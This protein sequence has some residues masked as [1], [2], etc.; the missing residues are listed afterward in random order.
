MS[1][2]R[3]LR[4]ELIIVEDIRRFFYVVCKTILFKEYSWKFQ[5]RWLQLIQVQC[6]LHSSEE[7]SPLDLLEVSFMHRQ[8]LVETSPDYLEWD[9]AWHKWNLYWMRDDCQFIWKTIT[10]LVYFTKALSVKKLSVVL[11]NFLQLCLNFGSQ[12]TVSHKQS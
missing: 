12:D 9:R 6:W 5:T 8:K 7:L 2:L 4:E 11:L 10:S 3:N 1:W